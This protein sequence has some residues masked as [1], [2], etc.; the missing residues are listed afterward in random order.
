MLHNAL[1]RQY[2]QELLPSF[3]LKNT[4]DLAVNPDAEDTVLFVILANENLCG[5][6]TNF[7]DNN[8]NESI[9]KISFL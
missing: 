6:N 8:P 9:D 4:N 7:G 3:N 1:L 2:L 5:G